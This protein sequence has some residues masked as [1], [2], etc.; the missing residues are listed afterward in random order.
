[1][2]TNNNRDKKQKTLLIIL[3][4]TKTTPINII[5]D[6][7][8]NIRGLDQEDHKCLRISESDGIGHSQKKGKVNIISMQSELTEN[9]KT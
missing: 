4:T 5:I 2:K 8:T 7:G 9:K 1:M 3:A 6:F